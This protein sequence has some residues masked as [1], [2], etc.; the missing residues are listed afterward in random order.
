MTIEE[1][2]KKK[3]NIQRKSFGVIAII[4]FL[5]AM[6]SE[7]KAAFIALGSAFLCLTASQGRKQKD[8]KAE[9]STR[10]NPG[11]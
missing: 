4:M 5:L 7:S 6:V 2:I 10:E 11:D 8:I 3:N 1:L 9:N